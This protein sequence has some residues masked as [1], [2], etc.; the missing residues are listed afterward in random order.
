M[1]KALIIIIVLLSII[2]LYLI[3]RAVV[4]H[5]NSEEKYGRFFKGG[6]TKNVSV[7]CIHRRHP[8]NTIQRIDIDTETGYGECPECGSSVYIKP[9]YLNIERKFTNAIMAKLMCKKEGVGGCGEKWFDVNPETGEAICCKCG[10]KIKGDL[11]EEIPYGKYPYDYVRGWE[12][13]G[14]NGDI[15]IPK[16][17]SNG[18]MEV[19]SMDENGKKVMG[20][21]K[22]V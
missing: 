5:C 19:I 2:I 16:R 17:S 18:I 9:K 12:F 11:V 15:C 14:M 8:F 3:V 21:K 20:F 4:Y 10:N 1:E 6:K 7:Y 22:F 13:D